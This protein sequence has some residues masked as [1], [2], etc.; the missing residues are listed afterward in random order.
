MT[1]RNIRS[2]FA[3]RG[4]TEVLC[5]GLALACVCCAQQDT[6][7]GFVYPDKHNSTDYRTLGK[8]DTL[9]ECREACRESLKSLDAVGTGDY[10][11]GKNCR[12]MESVPGIRI[13]EE[14]LR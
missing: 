10:K 6:W 1:R 13:C 2:V 7:D 8:F 9:E 3:M 4:F 11:C 14:T 5:L 12:D